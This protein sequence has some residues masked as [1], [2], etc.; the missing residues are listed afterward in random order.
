M[1][2]VHFYVRKILASSVLFMFL[3]TF[4]SGNVMA[5]GFTPRYSAPSRS[6]SVFYAGNP[7]FQ[8]GYGMPNCT[9]YAYG[10]AWEILGN[11]PNLS[12]G[13]AGQWWNYNKNGG[14]YEYGSTPRLGAVACWDK[15]DSNQGHVAVVEAVDGNQVTISESHYN[16]VNFDTRV[17]NADMSNYLTNMRFLGYIYRRF[18]GRTK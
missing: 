18:F 13:N 15:Y 14:Y 3:F 8:A 11:Q 9:A 1:K 6:D 12:R 16:G 7:F 2:K 10:R 4:V 5:E 17:R